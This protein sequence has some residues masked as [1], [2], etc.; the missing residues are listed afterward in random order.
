MFAPD[1]CSLNMPQ[2]YRNGLDG[3]CTIASGKSFGSGPL[4]APTNAP[5]KFAQAVAAT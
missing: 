1:A 4:C 5:A 3:G 2:V